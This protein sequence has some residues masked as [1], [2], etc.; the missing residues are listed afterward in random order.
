L[1][2]CAPSRPAVVLGKRRVTSVVPKVSLKKKGTSPRNGLLLSRRNAPAIVLAGAIF[3]LSLPFAAAQ[4]PAIAYSI[5]VANPEQHVAEVQIMLPSGAATRQLQLP[6][7]N[8]L[9]QVRDFSQYVN[10]VRAKD[11]SGHALDVQ[12]LDKSRWRIEGAT[13]GAVIEY[14]IYLDSPGPFGAQL[15]QHHAFLNLAQLLMYPVDARNAPMTVTF[16]HVPADW[17]IATPLAALSNEYVAENYDR[18]VDSPFELGTFHEANFDES[19]GHFRVIFDADPADYDS[20][21]IVSSLHRIVA[22]A[23]SWMNDRPF[24]TYT[25]FFHFPRGPGGGGMEHAYSTAIELNADVLKQNLGNLTSVTA[26]EF[27]HLWNVKRIRPQSLEPIDY[28]KENYTRALWFSEGVTSTAAGTI[29]LR[30]G[31]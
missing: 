15:N 14:Q 10:W 4:S 5:S 26:H 23:I 27:F 24:D 30:A 25:F 17:R 28:T 16:T 18:L 22:A 11:V 9:Y 8:A 2:F 7:W 20:A 21:K 1:D 29:E 19:G 31:D 3:A 6:V 13:A 12:L